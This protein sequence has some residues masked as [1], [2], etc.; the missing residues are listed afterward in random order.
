MGKLVTS[1]SNVAR[2]GKFRGGT[3]VCAPVQAV[4]HPEVQL[5][6]WVSFPVDLGEGSYRLDNVVLQQ[7]VADFS[8]QVVNEFGFDG[9]FLNI[10]PVWNNDRIL[11]VKP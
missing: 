3:D 7:I 11:C 2:R 9:V 8:A 1:G 6:G 4:S 5:Y 10:E